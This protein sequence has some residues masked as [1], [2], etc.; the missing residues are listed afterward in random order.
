MKI[1][2]TGASGTLAASL[3]KSDCFRD[4]EIILVDKIQKNEIIKKNNIS[5][6][7][8]IYEL[9]RDCQPDFVF[10]YAAM[11]NV[12][13]CEIDKLACVNDNYVATKNLADIAKEFDIPLVFISSA[14]IFNGSRIEYKKE[15][16]EPNPLNFYGF[17]KLLSEN[18]IVSKLNK[19]FIFRF[20]WLMGDPLVDQKFM[21]KIYKQITEKNSEM[22]GVN[23]QYGSLTFADGFV[24]DLHCILETQAYGIYNY[25]SEGSTSRY[26]IINAIVDY[27]NLEKII[28]VTPVNLAVFKMKAKRPKYELLDSSKIKMLH[29]KNLKCWEI[30]LT[31]YLKKHFSPFKEA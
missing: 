5:D 7:V 18:Y 9:I 25:T 23:D 8:G 13:Q 24:E 26:Q 11:T 22:I 29:V 10:H 31:D 19:Y 17:T 1:L 30:N 28:H 3:I 15:T 27:L 4:E 21:G 14:S 6:F 20:G 2:V 16:D 12:D